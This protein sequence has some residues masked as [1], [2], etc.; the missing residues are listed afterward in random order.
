MPDPRPSEITKQLRVQGTLQ[1]PTPT[2]GLLG[3]TQDTGTRSRARERRGC[4]ARNP[5][6]RV[7]GVQP[8]AK[9]TVVSRLLAPYRPSVTK[10]ELRCKLEFQL[11]WSRC[12]K[13]HGSRSARAQSDS[14][15]CAIH[16]TNQL[17]F[18]THWRARWSP[19]PCM[20]RKQPW[21]T[22]PY[23]CFAA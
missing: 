2:V 1:E 20:A 3:Q 17:H 9:S 8:R 18:L 14:L 13:S 21:W 11:V 10:R 12:A 15:Y 5:R 23:D 16:P 4:G 6:H 7:E 22:S 19:C